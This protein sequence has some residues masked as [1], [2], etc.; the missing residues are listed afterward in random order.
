MQ[1]ATR[2][3]T[4]RPNGGA[5]QASKVLGEEVVNRQNESLGK[6]QD[7]VLDAEDGRVSYAVLSFGGFLGMGNKLFAIPWQAFEH[8]AGKDKLILNVDKEKLQNAP[9][10]EKE[11]RWP[12]FADR[13]WGES[14]HSYYGYDTYWVP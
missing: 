5:V 9:G 2:R 4:S 7:M 13:A 14:I 11:G 3:T 8:H 12:D 10:F 6:I 1:E